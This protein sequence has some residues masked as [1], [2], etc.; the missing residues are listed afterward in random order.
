MAKRNKKGKH[1]SVRPAPQI[2]GPR[3][4]QQQVSKAEVLQALDL[5]FLDAGVVTTRDWQMC[6]IIVVGAGGIGAYMV[7]HVGRIM[8][9]IYQANKGVHLT[10]VDPDTV[11]EVNI[12]RQLFCEAEIGMPKAEALT[13][14]YGH[15]WGLN[16]SSY[17]GKFEESLIIDMGLTILVGCVDNAAA[18]RTMSQVLEHNPQE[19]EPVVWWLDCGNLQDTGAVRLG[20]ACEVDQLAGSFADKGKCYA[21]PSPA[22]QSPGLLE[23]APEDTSGHG[24]SCAE[25]VAAN[26]QS[27]NINARVAAEA[28]DF[29]TRL[30]VTK[31]LKRFAWEVNLAAGSARAQYTTAE[32][33]GHVIH[34]PARFLEQPAEIGT[35]TFGSDLFDRLTGEHEDE[36]DRLM[37][38]AG[39]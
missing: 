1:R 25:M 33:V 17:V 7:Q 10:V 6:Q 29:L 23:D 15:G 5:G 22:L 38:E 30:L 32:A 34:R 36:I 2:A 20:S 26:L 21:L 37:Q 3:P 16:C 11:E 35:E 19:G 18:R 4:A 27:L 12:G 8:R 13:R 14:R 24:M 39:I 9:A 31:D 28:S